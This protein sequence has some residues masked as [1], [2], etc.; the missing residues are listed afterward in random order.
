MADADPH[1]NEGKYPSKTSRCWQNITFD[2]VISILTL[3]VLAATMY[4]VFWYACEA[5]KQRVVS[6]QQIGLTQRALEAGTRAYLV[7]NVSPNGLDTGDGGT[8]LSI[9]LDVVNFG[10]LPADAY[11]RGR[12]IYSTIDEPKGPSFDASCIRESRAYIW[13]GQNNRVGKVSGC[14]VFTRGQL[15]DFRRRTGWLFLV[16]D[17]QYGRGYKSGICW[18]FTT[19]RDETVVPPSGPEPET[20]LEIPPDLCSAPNYDYAN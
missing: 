14:E 6:E 10:K 15:S 20:S 19:Q 16:V 1:K 17:I 8:P 3:S 4:G 7:P 11:I 5:K 12:I 2:R 18:R 13:P 9:W